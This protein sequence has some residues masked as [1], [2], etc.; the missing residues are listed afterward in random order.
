MPQAA[1]SLSTR[2][3]LFTQL[4]RFAT[5]G[6]ANTLLSYALYTALVAAR[7]PYPVAG[8]TGFVAGAVNGYVLNRRWTFACSDSARARTRYLVVQLGGLSATTALLWVI[9]TLGATGR[10]AGYA[11]TIPIVTL[12]TFGANRSWAFTDARV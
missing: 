3:K 6:V 5:V 4:C 12:A 10:L 2:S 11:L 1:R 9:V 7:V 8:A